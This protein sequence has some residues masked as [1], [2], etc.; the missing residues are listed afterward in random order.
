MG[1]L[2]EQGIYQP[3]EWNAV[4]RIYELTNKI[5]TGSGSGF[6]PEFAAIMPEMIKEDAGYE[7]R[8]K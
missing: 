6:D 5:T 3:S 8:E 4:D 2:S 1:C 7:L